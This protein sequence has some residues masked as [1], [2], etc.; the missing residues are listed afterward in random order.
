MNTETDKIGYV[1]AMDSEN[2]EVTVAE[3]M[4]LRLESIP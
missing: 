1:A 4:R 2:S 3:L